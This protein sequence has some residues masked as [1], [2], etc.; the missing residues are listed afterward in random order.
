[1]NKDDEILLELRRMI[2]LLALLATKGM[3][4]KEQI[5]ELS[6]AGF[7]PKEIS[8]LIGT[9]ANTVSVTLSGIRKEMKKK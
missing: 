7:Q 2:R 6:C 8:E 4:Q 5:W 9:T 1:M 3:N